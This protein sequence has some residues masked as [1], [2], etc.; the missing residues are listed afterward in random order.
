MHYL[1]PIMMRRHLLT[2]FAL[3][4]GFAALHSPASAS[5]LESMVFDARAF[6]RAN[7]TTS[8]QV[9]VCERRVNEAAKACPPTKSD[10]VL[11]RVLRRVRPPIIF[12]SERALE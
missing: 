12:G 8:S 5:S 4:S 1:A 6:A 10:S 2:L 3:F 9:C 7:D 11:P